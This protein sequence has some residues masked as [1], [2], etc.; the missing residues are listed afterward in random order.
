MPRG[1]VPK[2]AV[3]LRSEL[4]CGHY[5]CVFATDAPNVVY[6][7]TS[8]VS[9]AQFAALM[10]N[11]RSQPE[12][13]V[14]YLSIYRLPVMYR[15]RP[16][17]VL[18]R[19]E[20]F[21]VGATPSS[22]ELSARDYDGQTAREFRDRLYSFQTAAR[23]VRELLK[24]AT[25]PSKTLNDAKRYESWASEYAS[26]EEVT[27]KFGSYYPADSDRTGRF[28]RRYKGAQRLAAALMVCEFEA[29][30]MGNE[31]YAYHVGQA[32]EQFLERGVLLAD[33]HMGNIGRVRREGDDGGDFV[34]ITDPGHMIDLTGENAAT[35]RLLGR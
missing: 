6:K 14:N 7:V 33:V 16:V 12:G 24:R 32:L 17:F 5:G 31:P 9:E 4:G 15:K 28:L 3:R 10:V 22:S 13:V 1:D 30:M 23:D 35:P 21:R 29:Q 20:A 25:S 2:K 26:D 18:W 19:E 11:M 27:T 8:D 34:V